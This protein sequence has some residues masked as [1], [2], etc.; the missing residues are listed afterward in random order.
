MISVHF[1]REP[2]TDF[3]SAAKGDNET[4][5]RFFHGLLSKGVYIAPSAYETWFLCDALTYEDLD[6]TIK[7]AS[8]VAE[9]L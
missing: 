3:A 6:A 5:R 1:N 2:V 8:E 7:A 9:T 4:F